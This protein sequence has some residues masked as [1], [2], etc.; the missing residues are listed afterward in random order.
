[1]SETISR[2]Y[3]KKFTVVLDMGYGESFDFTN[4]VYNIT[5]T[6]DLFHPTVVGQARFLDAG[7]IVGTGAIKKNDAVEIAV[8]DSIKD[9]IK[10]LKFVIAEIRQIDSA[11]ASASNSTVWDIVFVSEEFIRDGSIS[12]SRAL[13][14]PNK[15][16]SD[17]VY[18][19]L[20][21]ELGAS[22]KKYDIE[23]TSSKLTNYIASN[24]TPF[25]VC[26]AMSPL[27]FSA[28]NPLGSLYL[29]FETLEGYTFRSFES[30]TNDIAVSKAIKYKDTKT[31]D[32]DNDIRAF[33]KLEFSEIDNGFKAQ[34]IGAAGS[35]TEVLNADSK[36]VT[37]MSHDPAKDGASN[38]KSDPNKR[39]SAGLKSQYKRIMLEDANGKAGANNRRNATLG[40][41]TAI[42]AAGEMD[43]SLDLCAGKMIDIYSPRNGSADD[44]EAGLDRKLYTGTYLLKA[45]CHRFTASGPVTKV[46]MIKNIFNMDPTGSYKKWK[47]ETQ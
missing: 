22:A 39:I 31:G 20:T 23:E 11:G 15:T 25:S 19:M 34:L 45:V 12:I 28:E 32:A 27:S 16:T 18:D 7:N 33:N 38:N 36:N 43:L 4:T 47:D 8:Y 35:T 26:Y 41:M 30:L 1:M 6:E 44:D 3:L 14:T 21:T 42:F 13:H 10:H 17:I 46:D 29:F 2:D 40:L 24:I 37:A 9:R 5:L